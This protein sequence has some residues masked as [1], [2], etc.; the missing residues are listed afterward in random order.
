MVCIYLTFFSD[1]VALF[2]FL[3]DNSNSLIVGVLIF[4]LVIWLKF[5]RYYRGAINSA[6]SYRANEEDKSLITPEYALRS[7]VAPAYQYSPF[8][9]QRGGQFSHLRSQV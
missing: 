4:G 9:G 3:G 1:K 2:S 7:A 5:S 6:D 8:P